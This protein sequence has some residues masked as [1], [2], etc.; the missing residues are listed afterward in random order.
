LHL[1][2]I[3]FPH[4]VKKVAKCGPLALRTSERSYNNAQ[5]VQNKY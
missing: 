3:L 5:D 4:S 1:V 2:G